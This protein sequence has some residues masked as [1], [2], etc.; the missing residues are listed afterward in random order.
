MK[1]ILLILSLCLAT[2]AGNSQITT[3][4][5]GNYRSIVVPL[6][7]AIGDYSK[8]VILLHE[9]YSGPMINANYAIGTITA[10]RGATWAYSRVDIANINSAAA[11]NGLNA[12][13][14]SIVNSTGPWKLKT[15][16]FNSKKYL[17]VEIP[18]SDAFHDQGYKFTGYYTSSGEN[19]LAIAYQVNGVAVNQSVL[20]DIQDFAPNMVQTNDVQ[21]SNFLGNV[22]IGTTDPKGYK[23]AV[24][25][26]MIAESVKIKLQGAWPDFV[27]SK[28]YQLPSLQET[29]KHILANGHLP[30]IPS[31]SEVSKEGIDLGEM[32]KKL[33]QKIEELTL[34]LI[35]MKKENDLQKE[36]INYL[37]SKI[38]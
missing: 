30:G 12:T 4:A 6:Y 2:I 5:P 14:S 9:I 21:Q 37:K 19:M 24:A 32:N 29:E 20:S 8:V 25:G 38:K 27:F 23:L 35:D 22:A 26:S 17:A 33:L 16:M 11:Y 1:K 28:K 36:D 15:C 7:S 3:V 31:A 10:L 13:I 34:Y 18:Y